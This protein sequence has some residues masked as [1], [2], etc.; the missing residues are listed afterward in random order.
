MVSQL[1]QPPRWAT[2]TKLLH[3]GSASKKGSPL[4]VK[5]THEMYEIAMRDPFTF[6][7]PTSTI[8]MTIMV[9]IDLP[10]AT[11]PQW[12]YKL[13]TALAMIRLDLPWPSPA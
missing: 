11:C 3:V 1:V 8:V 7:G 4:W 9:N 12:V 5:R 13:N 2:L 6:R 10:R